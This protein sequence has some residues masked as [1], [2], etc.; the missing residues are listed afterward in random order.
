MNTFTYSD[1]KQLRN[2]LQVTLDKICLESKFKEKSTDFVSPF[3][4]SRTVENSLVII[5][6]IL[7]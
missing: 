5:I 4:P 7:P 1:R 6:I 3:I 2:S